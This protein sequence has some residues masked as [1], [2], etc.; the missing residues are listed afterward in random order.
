[1]V[2]KAHLGAVTSLVRTRRWANAVAIAHEQSNVL[3]WAVRGL[4]ESAGDIEG[5]LGG[6]A[7]LVKNTRFLREAAV[8][9]PRRAPKASLSACTSRS[10]A[11]PSSL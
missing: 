7:T 11:P 5:G 4:L 9:I 1:V 3:A 10:A 8:Y 6:I 2:D